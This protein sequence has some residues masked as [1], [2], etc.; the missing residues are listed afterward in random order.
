MIKVTKTFRLNQRSTDKTTTKPIA[1]SAEFEAHL[2]AR[3]ALEAK[4]RKVCFDNQIKGL[5]EAT[6]IFHDE[7]HA[8]V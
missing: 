3:V 8:S 2:E 5:F 6:T 7:V 1:P 4:S